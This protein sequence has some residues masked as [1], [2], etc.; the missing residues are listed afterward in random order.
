M[1]STDETKGRMKE[2]AGVLSGDK[3][4]QR[5]GRIDQAAGKATEF[6]DKVAEKARDF[7]KHRKD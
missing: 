1:G 4:L 7:L 6:V 5:E 3:D 2:A